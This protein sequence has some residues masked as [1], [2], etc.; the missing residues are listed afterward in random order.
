[1]RA[2]AVEGDLDVSSVR[3]NTFEL[4]WPPR[5]G[6]HHRFPEVDR[7]GW[8]RLDDARERLVAGQVPLLERLAGALGGSGA[9]AGGD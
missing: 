5:S 6:Q 2:W 9:P 1:V 4:E 7:A 3:S 8:F